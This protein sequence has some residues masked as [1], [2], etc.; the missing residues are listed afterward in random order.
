MNLEG[1][2]KEKKSAVK[3]PYFKINVIKYSLQT[4]NFSQQHYI[5]SSH[6]KDSS[7]NITIFLPNM[8]SFNGTMQYQVCELVYTTKIAN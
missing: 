8:D 2:I 4:H 1:D 3:L 6:N 5:F 7:R